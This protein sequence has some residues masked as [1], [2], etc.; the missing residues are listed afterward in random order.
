MPLTKLQTTPGRVAGESA[1]YSCYNWCLTQGEWPR[2]LPFDDEIPCDHWNYSRRRHRSA[3][4]RD[5]KW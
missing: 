1:C 3:D 5:A 2:S 4:A